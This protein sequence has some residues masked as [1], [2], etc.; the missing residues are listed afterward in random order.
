MNYVVFLCMFFY[1]GF[2][3]IQPPIEYSVKPFF[4]MAERQ[5]DFIINVHEIKNSGINPSIAQ[6]SKLSKRYLL[7]SIFDRY[8]PYVFI[9]YDILLVV[10][11]LSHMY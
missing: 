10:C 3:I 7:V 5:R 1:Y 4:D 2:S 6:H 9:L 11:V 8:I